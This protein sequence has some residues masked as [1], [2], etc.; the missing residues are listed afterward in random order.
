MYSWAY[1]STGSMPAFSS[2]SFGQAPTFAT[3]TAVQSAMARI[4]VSRLVLVAEAALAVEIDAPVADELRAAGAQLVNL[5]L[6]GVAEMFVDAA[7]ALG[8]NRDQDL[9]IAHFAGERRQLRVFGG[10]LA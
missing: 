8:R 4:T 9:H 6:F 5:E 3:N 1:C 10:D 7:A 2:S